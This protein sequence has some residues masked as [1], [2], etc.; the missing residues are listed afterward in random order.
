MKKSE[1]ARYAGEGFSRDEIRRSLYLHGIRNFYQEV[2][3]DSEM[4]DAHRDISFTAAHVTQHSHHFLEI[5]CCIQGRLEYLLDTRRYQ[6]RSGDIIIVPPGVTHMPIL[7]DRM[8]SPYVRDVV[9]VSPMMLDYIRK[10]HPD[11]RGADRPIVLSTAGT[12]WEYLAGFFERN[13]RES[14]TRA[15]GWEVCVYGN[16]A[17][18]LVHLTR[19]VKEADTYA[20]AAPKEDLLEKV[21]DYVRE[22]MAGRITLSETARYFH[23]SESTLT[24]LFSREMGM[25]FYRCVTQRRLAEAKNQIARGLSMEETGRTVGY[26]E[27]SAFYRAFRT[28]YGISPLQYR[29]MIADQEKREEEWR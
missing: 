1:V 17:Q 16:T 11:F 4:A 3:M 13:T 9:W 25:G 29:K 15:A 28:E 6:V 14:E 22:N 21:L 7:P 10:M 12:G 23:I 26:S 5:V 8:T 27:Y 2:E 20:S 19:A 18:M 24:H